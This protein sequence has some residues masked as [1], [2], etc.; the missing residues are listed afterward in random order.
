MNYIYKNIKTI[1]KDKII[2]IIICKKNNNFYME[3]CF[4]DRIIA[5]EYEIVWYNTFDR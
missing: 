4:D 3:Y 2:E 1:D 5:R